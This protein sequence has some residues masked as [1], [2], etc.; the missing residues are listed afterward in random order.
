MPGPVVHAAPCDRPSNHHADVRRARTGARSGR[1][2]T[3]A[4]TPAKTGWRPTSR[5]RSRRGQA[6]HENCDGADARLALV[7]DAEQADARAR[8]ALA[9]RQ[10]R[11]G[12]VEDSGEPRRLTGL[13]A[14]RHDVLDIEAPLCRRCARCAAVRRRAP[15]WVRARTPRFSADEWSQRGHRPAEFA[16]EHGSQLLGLFLGGLGVDDGAQPPVALAS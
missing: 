4:A 13:D 3:R 9:T 7:L 16:A 1:A 2:G 11:A 6:A 12:R 14:E 5:R 15:R 8:F 10:L